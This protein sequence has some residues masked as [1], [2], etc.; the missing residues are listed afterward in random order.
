MQ[1][2]RILVKVRKNHQQKVV[3]VSNAKVRNA[4]KWAL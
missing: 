3:K 1:F 4:E 2:K